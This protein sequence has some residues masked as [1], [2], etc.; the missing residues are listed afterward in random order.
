[1]TRHLPAGSIPPLT[2]FASIVVVIGS[3]VLLG[4]GDGDSELANGVPWTVWK[5]CGGLAVGLFLTIF[6][7]GVRILRDPGDW[8]IVEAQ[9]RIRPYLLAIGVVLTAAFVWKALN[10]NYDPDLDAINDV[11]SRTNSL[12]LTALVAAAPMV[13]VVWLA[14]EECLR[15]REVM[16]GRSLGENV[17]HLLRLWRLLVTCIGAFAVGVVAALVTSGALRATQLAAHPDDVDR[18]PPSN[19]L[20]YGAFF[21][22]LL[23]LLALPMVLTWR[24]RARD[25]VSTAH[26]L[27]DDGLPTDAWASERDR[28]EK[29]LHLDTGLFANPLTALTIFTPLVT[30]LLAAFIPQLG[31]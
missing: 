1:M 12:L 26:P 28:L 20:F 15:L 13:T 2:T 24:A 4:V 31:S 3:A 16:P 23:T 10:W 6:V 30:S 7:L 19:V 25:L 5:L 18:F 11:Q 9:P 17:K 27:P 8:G 22:V 29:A 21:A 14:H